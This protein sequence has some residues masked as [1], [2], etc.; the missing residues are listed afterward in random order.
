MPYSSVFRQNLFVGKVVVVTG[1]GS[2]LGRCM[3]H[4]LS[5]LGASVA[6]VGRSLDR[7]ETAA[8][9]IAEDGGRASVHVCDIRDEEA[10]SAMVSGVLAH[11]GRVDGLVNNAGGQYIQPIRDMK[12]KGWRAVVDTNLTGGFLVS[13]EVYRSWMELNGGSIVNII[14][15]IWGGW[16][17]SAHSGAARAGMLSF[18]ESAA[19]EWAVSGV[20]VNAVAPGWIA[21]SGMDKYPAEAQAMF[22]RLRANVP[23][24]RLGTEAEVS[25]AVAYLLSPASAFTTGSYIRVDGGVPN[26]RPVWDLQDHSNSKPFEGFHRS[27]QPKALDAD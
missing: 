13:R 9:E 26:A 18:T 27:V 21:S 8:R 7:L 22:R 12:S 14:A 6:L 4:E 17:G 5:S 25:A 15:D 2:G 24:K 20:R 16:P 10:V 23:L 11:H 1:G 19:T 3:A